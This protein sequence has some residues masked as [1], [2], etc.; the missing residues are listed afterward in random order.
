MVALLGLGTTPEEA[1][2]SVR[3]MV[4]QREQQRLL[5][6]P[7]DSENDEV[8]EEVELGDKGQTVQEA[9][10][11]ELEGYEIRRMGLLNGL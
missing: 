8:R 4:L 9:L 1:K 6:F 2:S 10:A 3:M 7:S 11:R 5:P